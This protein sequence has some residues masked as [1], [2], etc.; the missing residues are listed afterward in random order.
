M[1]KTHFS[2]FPFPMVGEGKDRQYF[3]D[4][5]AR[6]KT[7]KD[8]VINLIVEITG[9]ADDKAEKKWYMETAGYQRSMP[10][11]ENTGMTN[12]ASLKSPRIFGTSKTS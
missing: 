9:F 2:A 7:G 1:S 3:P 4:F 12:G 6:C 10:S 8:S 11:G 5:I